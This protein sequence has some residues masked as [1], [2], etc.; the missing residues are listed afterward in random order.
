ML[1]RREFLTPQKSMDF[2]I[3]F[4]NRQTKNAMYLVCFAVA[5]F[6]FS[7]DIIAALVWYRENG[8]LYINLWEI[9]RFDRIFKK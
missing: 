7:I 6:L 4:R 5:R 3:D 2:K 8:P 1:E 9:D